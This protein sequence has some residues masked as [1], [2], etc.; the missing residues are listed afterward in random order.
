MILF[1]FIILCHIY[2]NNKYIYINNKSTKPSL[3]IFSLLFR[4]HKNEI[5]TYV[6]I[7]IIMNILISL[8]KVFC[9]YLK[10]NHLNFVKIKAE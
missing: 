4:L 6:R 5:T 9:K 2:N 3:L 8:R 1:L 10:S 7:Y